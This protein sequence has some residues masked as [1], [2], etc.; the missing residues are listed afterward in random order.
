MGSGPYSGAAFPSPFALEWVMDQILCKGW[1]VGLAEGLPALRI[2][3]L[4]LLC[5][6]GRSPTNAL[7]KTCVSRTLAVC[8][9]W[10]AVQKCEVYLLSSSF[11]VTVKLFTNCEGTTVPYFL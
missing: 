10:T 1:L 5:L 11:S 2:G 9:F 8:T 7:R 3:L 6:V 4:P